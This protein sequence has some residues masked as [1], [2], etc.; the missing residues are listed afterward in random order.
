M[1]TVRTVALFAAVALFGATIFLLRYALE[2]GFL[3]S[4]GLGL[5]CGAALILSFP[6]AKTGVGLAA[7]LIVLALVARRALGATPFT[8]PALRRPSVP[9]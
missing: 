9:T 1:N 6:Y 3:L 7:V 5:S 8:P 4:E 2:R